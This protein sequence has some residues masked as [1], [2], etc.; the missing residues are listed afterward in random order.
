MCFKESI[1]LRE[2]ETDRMSECL[3]GNDNIFS[4]LVMGFRV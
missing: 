2:G 3:P 4:E 1:R